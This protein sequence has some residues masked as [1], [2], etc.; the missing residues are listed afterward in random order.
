MRKWRKMTWVLIAW[1]LLIIIWMVA[2]GAANECGQEATELNQDAC[3]AGTGIG[4]AL[5]GFLGF[6]G[7]V[8]LALI[9]FMTRPKGRACPRCGENV[10][11]GQMVCPS[12]EFDFRTVGAS[13]PEVGSP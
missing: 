9:W 5:V 8:F 10:E 4:V 6:I 3:E 13:P 7:F 12:C 11:K 1:T 2:G